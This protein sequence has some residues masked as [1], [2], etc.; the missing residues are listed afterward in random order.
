MDKRINRDPATDFIRVFV[1]VGVITYHFWVYSNY[2]YKLS[3]SNLIYNSTFFMLSGYLIYQRY[4]NIKGVENTK[5]FYINRAKRIFPIYYLVWLFFYIDTVMKN[6]KNFFYAGKPFNILLTLLGL[7]GY[8]S[9]RFT[10]YYQVG[11]WF[12]GAI[13]ICYVMYP[14]L[15]KIYKKNKYIL[16]GTLCVVYAL[17]YYLNLPK[18]SIVYSSLVECLFKF[19]IGFYLYDNKDKFRDKKILLLC[20]AVILAYSGFKIKNKPILRT[21]NTCAYFVVLHFIGEILSKNKKIEKAIVF[22]SKQSFVALLI[23]HKLIYRV[24]QIYNPYMPIKAIMLTVLTI[25]LCF[26]IAYLVNIFYSALINKTKFKL[27]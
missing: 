6:G 27:Q 5:K 21:V 19:T 18:I 17:Y 1:T 25:I 14:L 7:D 12:F 20:V 13:I 23:Q 15:L 4:N 8:L 9:S 2:K 11:E 3:T 24:L 22:L 10:T 16:L 26:F